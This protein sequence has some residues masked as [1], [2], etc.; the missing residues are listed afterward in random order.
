MHQGL[1]TARGADPTH[2]WSSLAPAAFPNGLTLLLVQAELG[3]NGIQ[4][5]TP[6]LGKERRQGA[7]ISGLVTSSEVRLRD[8]W[9]LEPTQA[10]QTKKLRDGPTIALDTTARPHHRKW[11]EQCHCL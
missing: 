8:G 10:T 2:N 3:R 5:Q 7:W 6:H 9:G 4:I 1:A 11:R